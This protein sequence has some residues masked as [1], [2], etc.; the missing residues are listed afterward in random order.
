MPI[1]QML[2]K[3]IKNHEKNL[4]DNYLHFREKN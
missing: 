4:L 3:F 1:K 2:E